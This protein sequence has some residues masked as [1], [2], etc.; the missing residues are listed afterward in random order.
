MV[1]FYGHL[2]L[3]EVTIRS[4][5]EQIVFQI[6]LSTGS[7]VAG[8]HGFVLAAVGGATRK[9]MMLRFSLL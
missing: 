2:S 8:C 1:I 4:G 6:M 5:V 9:H 7:S 3:P